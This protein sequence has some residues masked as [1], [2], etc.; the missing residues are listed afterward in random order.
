MDETLISCLE[1]Y[2]EGWFKWD[3]REK[4]DVKESDLREY[5]T[6]EEISDDT[7]IYHKYAIYFNRTKEFPYYNE[8]GER[9]IFT[10]EDY[11]NDMAHCFD[12]DEF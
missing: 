7:S 3:V 11:I 4:P 5:L 8:N 2:L 6:D 10:I 9:L 12:D 1:A